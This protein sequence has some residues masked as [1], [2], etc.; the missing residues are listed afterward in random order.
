MYA[1]KNK[2]TGIDLKSSP[3]RK[4]HR[5]NDLEVGPLRQVLERSP[6]EQ[7]HR[8]K[9]PE[10]KLIGLRGQYIQIL[11]LCR[12][13]TLCTFKYPVEACLTAKT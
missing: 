3:T 9:P 10:A 13:V 8:S 6:Q 5:S 11:K 1:L 4:N 2:A 12:C 7:P